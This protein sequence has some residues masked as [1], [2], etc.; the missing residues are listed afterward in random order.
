MASGYPDHLAGD[1]VPL[2]AQIISIVDVYDAPTTDR[3]CTTRRCRR[4]RRSVSWSERSVAAGKAQRSSRRS[5]RSG[6]RAGSSRARCRRSAPILRNGGSSVSAGH[7]IP[8]LGI[9]RVGGERLVQKDDVR[10]Q[11]PAV[12]DRVF[13]VAGHVDDLQ[14]WMISA[15]LLREIRP[16]Q[17]RHDDVGQQQVDVLLRAE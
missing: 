6:N 15:Q 2:L 4:I 13:R 7:R 5:R 17:A 12:D 3:P 8:Q 11:H 9:E 10:R 14:V 16:A 1:D